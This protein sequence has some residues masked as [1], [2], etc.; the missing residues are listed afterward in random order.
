MTTTYPSLP[1]GQFDVLDALNLNFRVTRSG[2]AFSPWD[3]SPIETAAA[4]DV[5]TAVSAAVDVHGDE[6][7]AEPD[8]TDD[9]DDS[10]DASTGEARDLDRD[11]ATLVHEAEDTEVT[12]QPPTASTSSST[13]TKSTSRKKR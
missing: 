13:S 2:R 7:L 1:A 4:F 6:D 3:A 9:S 5:V 8:A 12:P 11:K 10:D